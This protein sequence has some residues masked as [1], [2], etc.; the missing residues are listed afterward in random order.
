VPAPTMRQVQAA[1]SVLEPQIANRKQ[2]FTYRKGCSC[3]PSRSAPSV[4]YATVYG[5]SHLKMSGLMA[6]NAG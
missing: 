1:F 5:L 6:Q 2:L 4:L 3:Y